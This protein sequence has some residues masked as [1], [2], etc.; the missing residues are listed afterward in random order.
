MQHIPNFK[1]AVGFFLKKDENGEVVKQKL[2]M[3]RS[4]FI[5]FSGVTTW[6]ICSYNSIV[7]ISYVSSTCHSFS[8]RNF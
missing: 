1:I 7:I 4:V 6:K 3:L 2:A 5:K 8:W